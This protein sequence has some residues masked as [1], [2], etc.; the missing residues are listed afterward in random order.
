AVPG[1][2]DEH[3]HLRGVVIVRIIGRELIKPFELSGIGIERHDGI[4]VEVVAFTLAGIPIRTWIACS[5]VSEIESGIV[6]T[7]RPD[8][9]SAMFPCVALTLPGFVTGFTG[10]GNG[11]EAPRFA[12]GTHIV[13]GNEAPNAKLS[14]GHTDDDLVFHDE[15]R[16]GHRITGGR[17]PNLRI[18]DGP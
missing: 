17:I 18:P 9:P 12:A 2:I 14:T 4:G 11:V 1:R 3:R 6:R 5:P 7:G 10:P 13:C 15:W 16:D 8:R